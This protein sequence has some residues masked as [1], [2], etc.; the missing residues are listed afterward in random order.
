[1]HYFLLVQIFYEIY[2]FH[3]MRPQ[4][5]TYGLCYMGAECVVGTAAP[6]LLS[7]MM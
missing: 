5:N 7:L 4:Y 1:M 2:L 3:Q 6:T